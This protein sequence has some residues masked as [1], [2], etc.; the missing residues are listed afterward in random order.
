MGTLALRGASVVVS[1]LVLAWCFGHARWPEPV[2]LAMSNLS[3]AIGGRGI[4]D[5][6]DLFMLRAFL[7]SLIIAI[8]VVTVVSRRIAGRRR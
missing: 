8:V 4:E 2:G 6:E 5:T 3:A 1:T 7:V